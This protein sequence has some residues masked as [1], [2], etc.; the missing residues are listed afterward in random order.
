[1]RSFPIAP[2][3]EQYIIPILLYGKTVVN[4]AQ[5][6]MLSLDIDKELLFLKEIWETKRPVSY[7]EGKTT[8]RVRLEAYEYSPD[9][10][11]DNQTGFEGT[12][13]VRLVT[14]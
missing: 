3:V 5:G 1:L 13:V 10:W 6:Q 4:D 7:L 12:M 9:D 8:R 14:I 11:S 2:P